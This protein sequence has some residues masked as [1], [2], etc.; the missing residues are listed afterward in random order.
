[1]PPARMLL[2]VILSTSLLFMVV[3]A[4]PDTQP[5]NFTHRAF[6][7]HRFDDNAKAFLGSLKE[8]KKLRSLSKEFLFAHNKVRQHVG[9]PLLTWD[10]KL[11]RYARRCATQRFLDCR[12]VHSYG[13][14]GE[15]LFWG[16]QDHWTPTEAVQSW[17]R[18]HRFYDPQNNFCDPGQMCGHYTQIVWRDTLRVGCA[19]KKCKN[20]GLYIICEYD[21]PGNYVN[22]SPFGIVGSP[23][24]PPS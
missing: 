11:A 18:E 1:M 9:E 13:P 6:R 4:L 19:R 17:V 5:F 2:S 23:V 21:P 15:N 12:M 14:Y 7:H 3:S 10:R 22:E 8:H 20:G 24:T 16:K